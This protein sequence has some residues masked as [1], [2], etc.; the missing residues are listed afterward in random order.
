M[1]DQTDIAKNED[2]PYH[3][4]EVSHKVLY[5]GRT[6]EMTESTKQFWMCHFCGFSQAV[7]ERKE[8]E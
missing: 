1:N 4:Y 5:N 6:P 8:T 3:G 2:C 7:K